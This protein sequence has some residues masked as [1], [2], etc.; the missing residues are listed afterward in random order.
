MQATAPAPGGLWRCQLRRGVRT[1][2]PDPRVGWRFFLPTTINF[3]SPYQSRLDVQL[4]SDTG[5]RLVLTRNPRCHWSLPRPSRSDNSRPPSLRRPPVRDGRHLKPTVAAASHESHPSVGDT[6]YFGK[7]VLSSQ[8]EIPSH[9]DGRAPYHRTC[10][11]AGVSNC[12]S[13]HMAF[14]SR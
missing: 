8:P 11:H 1:L 9:S 6:K 4:G 5:S 10:Y 2:R 3:S 13:K 7:P 14:I 12:A